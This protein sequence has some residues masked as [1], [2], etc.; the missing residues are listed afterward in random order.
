M[1]EVMDEREEAQKVVE[2]IKEEVFK[3]KRSFREFAIL[4]RTNAQSRSLED[5]L[6][7]SGMSYTIVGGVRFYERKEIKDVLAYLKLICNP[8]DSL[9]LKR[10]INFPLRGIGESTL[11]RVE[12]WAADNASDLFQATGKVEDIPDI[13]SR[14][15]KSVIAFYAMLQKYIDLKDKITPNELVRTVVDETG[16]L[17]M[18]KG[19]TSVE[20]QGRAENIR[21]F[22]SAVSEYVD[23]SESPSLAGFLEEVSLVSDVDTW[24]DKSNAITL[25]TLHCAKGLEFPVV[26]ITGM[27]EGL[28]PVPRSLDEPE[29]LEEERRLFYV[30]L[31]RAKDKI[32]LSWAERR[33][34]FSEANFRIPSRF[35]DEIDPTVVRKT[36][37]E[38]RQTRFER[39]RLHKNIEEQFDSHPAYESFSQEDSCFQ[40][41]ARVHHEMFGDGTIVNL[42]GVGTK[43]KV[44][45]QFEKGV[46]KK[47]LLQYARFETL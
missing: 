47:F 18:Y 16:L 45:V 40:R 14:I 3:R 31:T 5:S 42:E 19:D 9:N 2:R 22:L 41:G 32:Y 11:K 20:G 17:T 28:F 46:K 12:T 15:K 29:A 8:R 6:R 30:G 37:P 34:L 4:Y 10:I 21:E 38:K 35:L 39:S 44:V 43:K 13:P 36:R 33:R 7:R 23:S 1:M 24:N 26:F 25:M 27:E